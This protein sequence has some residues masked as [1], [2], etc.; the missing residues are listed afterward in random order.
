MDSPPEGSGKKAG[1]GAIVA[2]IVAFALKFKALFAIVASSWSLILSLWLYALAFGWRFGVILILIVLLHE[3]GHY[4][5]FRAYGLPVRLPVFIPF[6]GAF[7]AGVAPHD[8]EQGAYIALAGPVVG[9]AVA[10]ACYAL[11]AATSDH[12]WYAC[13]SVSAFMNLFNM[14]PFPP[15]DGGRVVGSARVLTGTSRYVIFGWYAAVAAGL[16][17]MMWQTYLAIGMTP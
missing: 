1:A 10:G 17:I 7:T 16:G 11:G 8:P 4:A 14:I 3:L 12:F 9:F 15:L 2:A 13:A 6:F 5:A